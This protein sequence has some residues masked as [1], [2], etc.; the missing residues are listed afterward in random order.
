MKDWLY[1]EILSKKSYRAQQLLILIAHLVLLKWILFTLSES[2]RMPTLH[3]LLH[4]TG[5]SF[6]GA[7][8]IRACAFWANYH[9]QKELQDSDDK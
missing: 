5:I 1:R 7:F 2:G 4:F 8:L 9:Y 6:Y 3:V